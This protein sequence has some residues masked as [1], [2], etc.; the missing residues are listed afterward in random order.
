VTPRISPHDA[1]RGSKD[2][3]RHC[4]AAGWLESSRRWGRV[5]DVSVRLPII[6]MPE[7]PV[8]EMAPQRAADPMPD[9]GHANRKG[10]RT[11][12]TL[13]AASHPQS[14]ESRRGL[15]RQQ[16]AKLVVLYGR[17]VKLSTKAPIGSFDCASVSPSAAI[18]GKRMGR[19]VQGVVRANIC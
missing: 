5:R 1:A 4:A 8:R 2:V 18:R 17:C 16:S 19:P 13:I 6:W 15:P 14:S 3:V 9:S 11:I 10:D 7:R 12:P